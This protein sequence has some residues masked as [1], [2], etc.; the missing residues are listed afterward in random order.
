MWYHYSAVAKMAAATGNN[1]VEALE[2]SEKAINIFHASC[3]ERKEQCRMMSVVSVFG[4]NYGI[5][6]DL[7]LLYFADPK[8]FTVHNIE[9]H[10]KNCA[11]CIAMENFLKE[12]RT[13]RLMEMIPS[14]VIFYVM[15]NHEVK[16]EWDASQQNCVVQ[17]KFV[18]I[19]E[20]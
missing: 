13:Q 11:L 16:C 19:G 1:N 15:G 14:S 6:G 8:R 7:E 17:A 2:W 20:F 18:D 12:T 3:V 9:E 10:A 4:I 5:V